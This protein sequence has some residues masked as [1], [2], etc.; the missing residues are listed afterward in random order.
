LRGLLATTAV[1][2]AALTGQTGAAT[3]TPAFTAG[4]LVDLARQQLDGADTSRLRG[5]PG[6]A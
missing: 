1:G 6:A 3:K 2:T 4:R 5:H